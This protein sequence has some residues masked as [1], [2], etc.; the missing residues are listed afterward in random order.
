MSLRDQAFMA[1]IRRIPRQRL[2]A[3]AGKIAQQ[4]VPTSL[5]ESFYGTFAWAVGAN[6][7]ESAEPLKSFDSFNQFFTR[8]LVSGVRPWNG[9]PNDWTMPADGTMSVTGRVKQGEMLQVKGINYRVEDLLLED[10]APWEGARY[11]TIYL[12]PADYHRVHWPV[13]GTVHHV[14]SAGGEL[15]PVNRASVHHV[16]DLFIENERTISRV[17]DMNGRQGAVVMVGA[18]IVGGIELKV[19]SASQENPAS[20]AAGEEHGRF[21]LGSTVVLI[22]QDHDNPL[23]EYTGVADAHVRLGE[24]LWPNIYGT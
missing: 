13:S 4:H 15:W 6:L 2:T 16:P 20:F 24:P 9:G 10:A 12:S 8:E 5:R 18:T 1:A 19:S 23:G 14:R 7:T 11:A 3:L 21:Y 22:V 17:T